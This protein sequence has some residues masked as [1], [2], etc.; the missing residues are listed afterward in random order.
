[1]LNGKRIVIVMP[2]SKA[3][4]SPRQTDAEIPHDVVDSVFLVDAS[5]DETVALATDKKR[6]LRACG[7]A[8][9]MGW[10]WRGRR[11]ANLLARAG[12]RHDPMFD[13]CGNTL[14]DAVSESEPSP[15][16]TRRCT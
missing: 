10:A 2:A 11:V 16:P 8:G 15:S 4:R 12:V 9:S 3:S 1:M 7:G 5:H 14:R 13:P 6:H